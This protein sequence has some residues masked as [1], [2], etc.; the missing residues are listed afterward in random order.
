MRKNSILKNVYNDCEKKMRKAVLILTFSEIAAGF[1]YIMT[2]NTLG[3]FADSAFELNL[4]SGI[5]DAIVLLVYIFLSVVIIPVISLIGNCSMFKQ[6]LIHD[7]LIFKKFLDK[8]IEKVASLDSGDTQ[9]QLEDAPNNLRIFWVVILSKSLSAPICLI[10]LLLNALRINIML[11]ILVFILSFANLLIPLLLQTKLTKYE[12]N[13]KSYKALRR[14]LETEITK[15]PHL[16]KLWGLKNVLSKSINVAY[17]IYHKKT[18]FPKL[19]INNILNFG[20]TFLEY[21]GMLLV[22]IVG[23]KLI[24]NKF[25]SPGNLLTMLAYISV[26]QVFLSKIGE[27]IGKIPLLKVSANR[28]CRIYEDKEE[29]GNNNINHFE[30]LL[31]ENLEYSYN[32]NKVLKEL[33]LSI[34]KGDKIL[35]V[36]DNGSGKSTLI[37]IICTILKP[38]KGK[39]LIN[40]Q[41]IS[42]INLSSYRNL[43]AYAPQEPYLFNTTVRENITF[44][45]SKIDNEK[46]IEL[47]ENFRIIDLSEKEICS[48][49][50]LSG[51][52]K[53]KVSIIRAL[54]KD[55]EIVVLDE[56]TN[57]LDKESI[58]YLKKY[59]IN[60]DKTII[61]ITHSKKMGE[62]PFRKIYLQCMT[63]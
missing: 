62:L 2:S 35:I 32:N 36:G 20:S 46:Y 9:F 47:M 24:S 40:N 12:K 27:V 26:I 61:I 11:T 39:I 25:I 41:N 50:D 59:L 4:K 55:S 7:R 21:I 57:H 42:T 1:I 13:E 63:F 3:Q 38:T 52:E 18:E 45:N 31:I 29:E 60:I 22:F 17:D 37:K 48:K 19:I 14:A 8:D 6:A 23:V 43:F 33:N 16:I 5:K 51:G 53:Q 44:N 34:K 58:S 49:N 56:P 15:N 10:Y 28:T 54:L 30:Q